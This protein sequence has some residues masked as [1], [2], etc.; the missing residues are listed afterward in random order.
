M[1]EPSSLSAAVAVSSK[2]KLKS[3][4]TC[5]FLVSVVLSDFVTSRHAGNKL[6]AVPVPLSG[7]VRLL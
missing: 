7:F 5:K 6:S 4:S 1:D 2:E 3:P